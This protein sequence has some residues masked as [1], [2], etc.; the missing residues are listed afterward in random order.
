MSM[1]YTQQK[2]YE[3]SIATASRYFPARQRLTSS[4]ARAAV[5]A[6]AAVGMVSLLKWASGILAGV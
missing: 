3:T 5:E 4:W 1:C 2:S 6:G